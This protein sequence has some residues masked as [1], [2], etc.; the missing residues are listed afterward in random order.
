MGGLFC[1]NLKPAGQAVVELRRFIGHREKVIFWQWLPRLGAS[2]IL[3]D[4]RGVALFKHSAD[5]CFLCLL[6]RRSG[7]L[8][9]PTS[10][11]LGCALRCARQASSYGVRL[12]QL[13]GI[14]PPGSPAR[15]EESPG[16]LSDNPPHS[17]NEN[18]IARVLWQLGSCMRAL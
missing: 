7:R 16:S 15:P 13:P 6:L 18:D 2:S 10:D 5:C 8:L 11:A 9:R 12:C 4:K 3:L 14:P 1:F 17:F